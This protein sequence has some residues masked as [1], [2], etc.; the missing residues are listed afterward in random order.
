MSKF[1]PDAVIDL[2]LAG[3]ATATLMSACDDASTP[4]DG[5]F[6]ASTLASVAMVAGHGNSYTIGAGDA[7]GRK[8]AMDE[9]A[10]VSITAT[11]DAQ[12]IVLSL[13]GTILDV[14]TC[15]TQT[16]TSGG[17]VTFPTWDH[18]VIDPT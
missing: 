7:S 10:G 8:V 4:T 5:N 16:L 17:T 9:K 1:V 11:G 2:L 14:T 15:T 3:V 18:E 12:H 6:T 13:A